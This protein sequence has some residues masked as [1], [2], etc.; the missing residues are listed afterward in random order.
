M[1]LG[2]NIFRTIKQGTVITTDYNSDDDEIKFKTDGTNSNQY[3]K[4]C[5]GL[6]QWELTTILPTPTR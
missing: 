3:S 2:P 4:D 6:T 1:K 5:N